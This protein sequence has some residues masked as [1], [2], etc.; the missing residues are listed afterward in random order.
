MEHCGID[1]HLKSSEACVLDGAGAVSE[2]ARIP[3]T[4]KAFRRWFG[5]RERMRICI[6]ASGLSPWVARIL[7]ELGH[8]VIVANAQRVRLIAESTLKNDNIRYRVSPSHL[9]VVQSRSSA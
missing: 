8:E 1:L 5:G 6:E 2:T 3:T 9:V 7:A 4:E